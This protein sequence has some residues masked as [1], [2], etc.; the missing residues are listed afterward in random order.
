MAFTPI[1]KGFSKKPR[2]QYFRAGPLGGHNVC[3]TFPHHHLNPLTQPPSQMIRDQLPIGTWL[4]I[5]ALL[6]GLLSFLPYRNLLLILPVLALLAFKLL[7]TALQTL[8]LIPNPWIADA[9]PNRTA[10]LY[11]NEH[12]EYENPGD[13]AICTIMLAA[14]SNHP[15]GMLGPGF[16]EVGDRFTVMTRELDADPTTHGYL[17][18]STWLNSSDRTSGNEQ[19]VLMYFK[20]LAA[21]HAYAHGPQHTATMLWWQQNAHKMKHVG[22]MHEIYAAPK[23]ASEGIYVNY[24]PTGLGATF[25]E[26]RVGK[27]GERVW[28]SPLVQGKGRLTYSKGRMG[29][30]L[31]EKTEWAAFEETLGKEDGRY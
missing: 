14:R 7:T 30:G 28:M 26:A 9:I 15:L 19:M 4:A 8:N 23:H 20:S 1:F 10:I 5:G 18:S 22:I 21:C 17:G 3:R 27:E 16:K 24:H 6:Q 29:R 25:T 12:G 11:A 13:Q 2:S 31:D